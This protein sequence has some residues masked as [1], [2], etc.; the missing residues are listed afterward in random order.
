MADHLE[1]YEGTM[2]PMER[3]VPR[4]GLGDW[5]DLLH[6]YLNYNSLPPQQRMQR[7]TYND[8]DPYLPASQNVTWIGGRQMENSHADPAQSDPQSYGVGNWKLGGSQFGFTNDRMPDANPKLSYPP[9]TL[10]NWR[11]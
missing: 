2:A 11:Y 7:P 1:T 6:H 4:M 10:D 8:S 9:Y 3:Q 5:I